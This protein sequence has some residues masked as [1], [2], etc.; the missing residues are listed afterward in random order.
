MLLASLSAGFQSLPPLPTIKLGPSGA[1][2]QVSGSVY[3]LGPCGSLQ[4]TLLRGWGFLLLPPQPPRVFSIR[5]LR[6][7]FPC[8]GALGCVVCFTPPPF[9]P[10]YLCVNV[11]LWGATCHSACPILHHSK[12][13]PLGVSVCEC[14]SAGSASGQTDCPFRP[15]LRQ[16]RSLH[17]HMSPLCPS[18]Q[19][20]CMF[21]FYLLGVGLPC[22][23]IFSQFWFCEEAQ[24][25]YLRLHLGS[26]NIFL[27][28]NKNQLGVGF[29]F[30]ITIFD[31]K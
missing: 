29:L 28:K 26:R 12:S 22:C 31:S 30:N 25:V 9:L 4:R 16:S 11:G 18:Y 21:L 8:A 13:G 23:S 2:S 3:V 10:V 15:T 24:C 20:G 19:S 6:L 27:K 1:D 14:G 17:G 7:Y 5:G